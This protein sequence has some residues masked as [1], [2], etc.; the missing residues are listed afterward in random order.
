MNKCEHF[1]QV[2][3]FQFVPIYGFDKGNIVMSVYAY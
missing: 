2:S 1:V 3:Q